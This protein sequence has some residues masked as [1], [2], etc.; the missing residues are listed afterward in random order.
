MHGIQVG[1]GP[2]MTKAQEG[3]EEAAAKLVLEGKIKNKETRYNGIKEAGHALADVH[4]GKTLG[5]TV[6]IVS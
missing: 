5:K 1:F 4:L 6:I 2:I 3:F